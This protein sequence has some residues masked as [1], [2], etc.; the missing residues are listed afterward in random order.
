MPELPGYKMA[1]RISATEM[2]NG[3]DG[4]KIE[5]VDNATLNRLAD[6][7]E[8]TQLGDT[9]KK[10]MGGLKDSSVALS[11]NYRPDDT[12]G[13]L[14]LEPGDD[15]YI[16]MFPEGTTKAGKQIQM[17]VENF[18]HA[19]AADGKQTF[20]ATVQGNGAPAAISAAS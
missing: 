18:E 13:Q 5:G 2:S 7:L 16:A 17:I 3:S 4:Y 6:I 10:R 20:S 12:N 9:Y 11:G 19:S 14:A 15:V 1:V 8:I